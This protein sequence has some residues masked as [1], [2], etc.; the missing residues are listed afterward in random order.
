L[1]VRIYAAF[2]GT[3]RFGIMRVESRSVRIVWE[4]TTVCR[5]FAM[6]ILR[7]ERK[8]KRKKKMKKM[9]KVG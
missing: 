3:Y 4:D 5:C 9:K 8:K 1:Q 7:R 6:G 2:G